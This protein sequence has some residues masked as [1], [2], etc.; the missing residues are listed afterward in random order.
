MNPFAKVGWCA[1]FGL[2]LV[3]GIAA[4]SHQAPQPQ[5]QH[6]DPVRA[7]HDVNVGKFYMKRGDL[8]GA[9]ARFKDALLY[10]PH[11]A[12]ACLLLGQA[13]EKSND[14]GRAITYYQEYLKILPNTHESKKLHGHIAALQKKIATDKPASTGRNL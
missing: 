6:F 8:G 12:E 13:Y 9:I 4:Q 1:I 3:P 5:E 7:V 14:P 2:W 11:Y 10:K